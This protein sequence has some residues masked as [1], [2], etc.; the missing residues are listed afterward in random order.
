MNSTLIAQFVPLFQ[1]LC[2]ILLIVILIFSVRKQ[3]MMLLEKICSA[4]EVEMSL[5]ALTVQAKTMRELHRSIGTGFPDQKI[6]KEE[7]EGLIDIK[8]KGIQSAM[9]QTISKGDGRY[10]N[11]FHVNDEIRISCS[12]GK[13]IHGTTIDVS[14]AGIGFKSDERLRFGE[15][16][17]ILPNDPQSKNDDLIRDAV[18]IV[19]IEEAK[20]SYYYGATVA[21]Y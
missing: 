4:D 10:D 1:T 21:N 7:I 14:E 19:R 2:W 9:E 12:D 5:G 3:L 16:I 15:V 11:R 8:L 18:K 6:N 20:G 13:T 17:T